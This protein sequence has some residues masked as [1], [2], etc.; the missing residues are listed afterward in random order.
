MSKDP[1]ISIIIVN[2]NSRNYLRKCLQSIYAHTKGIAFEI[3]V[4]DGGSFDGCR[5]MLEAEFKDVIF[6]QSAENIGFAKANNLGVTRA[7][8]DTFLFLNPDTELLSNSLPVLH[9]RL[10]SIASAGAVGCK[11]LNGDGSLQTICVQAFPTVLNQVLDS[12]FLRKRLLKSRLFGTRAFAET[13]SGPFEV[14]VVSGACIMVRRSIFELVGGFTGQYFM[15]GEDLDLN[16]KIHRAG[17][18]VFYVPET[19]IIHFGGG[20]TAPGPA[21]IMMLRRSVHLFFTLHRGAASAA[22]Y[23]W[24]LGAT[25]LIRLGC[26]LPLLV[27]PDLGILQHGKGS[28]RK[29]TSILRWSLGLKPGAAALN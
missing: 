28:L 17:F 18:Q 9:S 12:E 10:Q 20:S 2:W 23:R 24:A 16:F 6:I 3:I 7:R 15:Y 13:G 14:E 1:Q 19:S 5:E 21:S 27:L 25:S 22:A 11:L 8:G 26:I 29:W 4:V